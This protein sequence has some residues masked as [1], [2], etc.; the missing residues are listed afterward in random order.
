MCPQS[1]PVLDYA[2]TPTLF[3]WRG[4]QGRCA[5]RTPHAISNRPQ[6]PVPSPHLSSTALGHLLFF[7]G[8]GSRAAAQ[9]EHCMPSPIVPSPQSPVPT[10][11]R[12]RSDTGSSSLERGAGP[13][14]KTNAACHRT[15]PTV[16]LS[17]V[18]SPQSSSLKPITYHLSPFT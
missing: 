10:C 4:E 8:E 12:L 13:L 9:D 2:R 16:S 7:I 1:P 5:R 3:H 14:R 15:T 18:P 11:P 6:S 17:P